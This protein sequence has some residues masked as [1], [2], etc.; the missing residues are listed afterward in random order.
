MGGMLKSKD[1]LNHSNNYEPLRSLLRT[2]SWQMDS[3]AQPYFFKNYCLINIWILI[4][5]HPYTGAQ[6]ALKHW[7]MEKHPARIQALKN[8]M[9]HVTWWLSIH[10][11]WLHRFSRPYQ[12]LN[13]KDLYS[14]HN[15][16]EPSVNVPVQP[17][18]SCT[19]APNWIQVWKTYWWC[20]RFYSL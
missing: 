11:S 12:R 17:L 8:L 9:G 3:C 16:Y 4:Y 18:E 6:H 15:I 1:G 10:G 14:H 20:Y 2:R 7:Q 19:K 13:A 5:M